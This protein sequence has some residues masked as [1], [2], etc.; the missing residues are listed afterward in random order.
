MSIALA[1]E[2]LSF[3]YAGGFGLKDIQ[4]AIAPGQFGVLL[5]PN[6]A[7]K[8]TLICLLTRLFAPQNG[9]ITIGAHDLNRQPCD[10]LAQLGVVFQQPTLDLDLSVERNLAYAASL[11]GLRGTQ[12]RHRM[13]AELA[14]FGLTEFRRTDTR[15][16]SG[17][18]KRKLELARALLHRPKVLI[19]DEATVGLDVPSRR[20]VLQHV[21]SLCDQEGLAVLWTTHVLEEI[22]DTDQLMVMK[23]GRAQSLGT[24]A[25]AKQAQAAT[26]IQ[27]LYDRLM[28]TGS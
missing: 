26:D 6:G 19:C 9:H 27:L 12:A 22:H 16:L 21:R 23:A 20:A 2:Q 4:L 24:V 8:T 15:R 17:G 1:T 11:Y 14:R 5:G 18:N 7:G 28:G 3:A 13:D 10:A 25:Q